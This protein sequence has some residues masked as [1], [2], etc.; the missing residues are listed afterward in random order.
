M[1]EGLKKTGKIA[2]FI[3]TPTIILI[4]VLV[5]IWAYKKYKA[6]QN[7]S[8][9]GDAD[10]PEIAG[11]KK[12]RIELPFAYQQ[13]LFTEGKFFDAIIKVNYSLIDEKVENNMI[14]V[15]ILMKP[16]DLQ[17]MKEILDGLNSEITI[18]QL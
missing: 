2:L 15:D 10:A 12:F 5:G 8:K 6:K 11:M 16:E 18:K 3:I 9:A 13:P 17:S 14:I 4:I 7:T 1:S